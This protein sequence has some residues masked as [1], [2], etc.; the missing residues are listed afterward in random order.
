MFMNV[1]QTGKL[2]RLSSYELLYTILFLMAGTA[3]EP[4]V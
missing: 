1:Q 2:L 3:L 4:R